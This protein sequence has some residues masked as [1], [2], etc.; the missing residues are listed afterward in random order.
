[1][2][3][4]IDVCMVCI[5][6]GVG[7]DVYVCIDVCVCRCVDACVYICAYPSVE[8]RDQPQVCSSSAVPHV[9][10]QTL[11]LAWSSPRR[12]GWPASELQGS[13]C[14]CLPGA[15]ITSCT[16]TVSSF[17]R[18]FWGLHSLR[19]SG[20]C[21]K[22]CQTTPSPQSSKPS[23]FPCVPALWCSMRWNNGIGWFTLCP[24]L[25]W[26]LPNGYN[27]IVGEAGITWASTQ[28]KLK[29]PERLQ[30]VC[31]FLPRM[32]AFKSSAEREEQLLNCALHISLSQTF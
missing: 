3:E 25:V 32:N 11:S 27:E 22:H 8:F 16:T 17:S 15:G 30:S 18:G 21:S 2:H 19:S 24:G 13:A 14:L 29:W 7:I 10:K 31:F 26:L 23:L 6:V 28:R 12:L 4:Y 5:D 1:M 20:L 9:L